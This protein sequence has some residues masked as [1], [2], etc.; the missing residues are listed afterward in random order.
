MKSERRPGVPIALGRTAEIYAWQDD[1]VL[2]LFRPGWGETDAHTEAEK[3]EAIHSACLPVPAVFE[4]LQVNGR[5]GILYERIEGV[6]LLHILQAKPWTFMSAARLLADLHLELHR[7]RLPE[8]PS[9][10]NRLNARIQEVGGMPEDMR[11]TL[12]EIWMALPEG[13]VVCHGDFHPGNVFITARGPVILDW[14]DAAA[15][16]PLGDVAR[17]SLLLSKLPLP[18]DIPKRRMIWLIRSQFHKF[19]IKRYFHKVAVDPAGWNAWQ[20]VVAAARLAE[21]VPGEREQLIDLVRRGLHR[22]A[23]SL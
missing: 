14:M 5:S 21:G 13:E 18:P 4:V 23:G 19:Y 9:L 12:T 10:K 22:Q 16:N 15:G 17:T 2:K 6:P 7:C 20:T 11:K 3:A 8:L 1:R